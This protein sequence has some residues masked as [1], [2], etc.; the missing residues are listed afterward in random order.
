MPIAPSSW[1]GPS[2]AIVAGWT[3]SRDERHVRRRPPNDAPWL[4]TII[5][6][7]LGRRVDPERHGRR[8]RRAQDVRLAD[9][10]EQVRH[11][12]AAA[13]LDVIGVDGPAGDR[14][15]R[16]L[17]LGRLVQA[18]GVERDGDVVG[19]GEAQDV[20]DQLGVGA[21]VLVDLEA[22]RAGVEE[23]L[24]RARRPRIRAPAWRPM[25]TGQP[26]RPG[27][28]PLHRP[29]RLLEAGRDERRDAARQRGRQE[30]RADRVDVAVD[31]A[32]GRD[33]AVA[34]DRLGV[35]PD[36]QL[37]AVA[38]RAVA[39]PADADDPAVLDPDVGLDAPMTGR[40]R[41][42]PAMTTSSSDGPGAA[43]G[44]I[45]GRIVFA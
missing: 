2:A 17:E 41:A 14:G 10:P 29:R 4:R 35:R 3:R 27:E 22:A 16:V 37:D 32:R 39:R 12:A 31:R 21:V 1:S 7:L 42:T 40:G 18:V 5:G 34:H 6:T 23:R 25:L 13:A 28:R 19:V 30:R 8:R 20:V 9:E 36:R 43:L 38:D 15:D 26:S 33:Q 11:V 44:G 24:E 45:R